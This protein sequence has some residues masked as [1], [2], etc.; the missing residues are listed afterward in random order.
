MG[1]VSVGAIPVETVR[2]L[3]RRVRTMWWVAGA[4]AAVAVTLAALAVDLL[5]QGRPG[6]L[7]ACAAAASGAL[8]AVLPALRYH[9]WRYALRPRDLWIQRGAIW[10]TVSVI[11]YRRLQFVD[12]RQGP[13]ERLFGLAQLIVYTAAPGTSGRLPGLDA[14][15]AEQLRERLGDVERAAPGV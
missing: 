13:L 11:P 9:R 1:S 12:T 6:L 3:D 8:A 15:Q 7:T 2:K 10:V 5:L 14:A 4:L